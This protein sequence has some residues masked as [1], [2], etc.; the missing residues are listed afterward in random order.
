MIKSKIF[1]NGNT[2][3]EKGFIGV[4]KQT[5]YDKEYSISDLKITGNVRGSYIKKS[6][7]IDSLLDKDILLEI[8]KF[9]YDISQDEKS[10]NNAISESIHG[11]DGGNRFNY[12]VHLAYQQAWGPTAAAQQLGRY[13]SVNIIN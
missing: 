13:S 7:N 9:F 5:S 11:I 3:P 4:F 10:R 12:R 6:Y 8:L 1:Q 2:R